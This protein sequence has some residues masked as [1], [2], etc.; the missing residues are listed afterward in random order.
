[1]LGQTPPARILDVGCG[2]GQVV[3]T[4]DESGFHA[5]GVEINEENLALADP[6][7]APRLQLYDGRNLPFADEEFAAVGAFNVLEHVDNPVAFLDEMARALQPGGRMVVSSPNFLRVLGWRDYHPRMQGFRQKWRNARTLLR[8]WRAY[9]VGKTLT[10]ETMIP[11]TRES[12][13]PDDD[14][15]TATNALDMHHY[16]R[17]RNFT[18]IRVSCVDRP[19]PRWLESLLDATPLRY[20]MLNSF[21]TATKPF[22]AQR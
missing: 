10:F 11:I 4:L 2:V 7:A 9:A 12:A 20:V 3:R 13:L 8:H 1:M 5:R 19:I 14:A 22:P 6:L 21:V 16:F 17:A 18:G 15:I